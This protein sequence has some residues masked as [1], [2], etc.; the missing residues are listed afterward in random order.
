MK[1]CQTRKLW[2]IAL[3][4]VC[5][6][7]CGGQAQSSVPTEPASP[8][9]TGTP[10]YPQASLPVP[11]FT[12]QELEAM[13]IPGDLDEKSLRSI[14]YM[15]GNKKI[16]MILSM[17][18]QWVQIKPEGAS[19]NQCYFALRADE[20]NQTMF[21]ISSHEEALKDRE[22][23]ETLLSYVEEKWE[24]YRSRQ[25]TEGGNTIENVAAIQKI[26]VGR[27]IGG[28]IRFESIHSNG[29]R[30]INHFII[31]ATDQKVYWCTVTANPSYWVYTEDCMQ[32][33]L[34]GFVTFD[35]AMAMQE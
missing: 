2:L 21:S 8:S 22:N 4:M 6:A 18:I 33:M 19:E 12:S 24:E 28:D 3:A 13:G 1:R 17:P 32:T 16:D 10:A 14:E 26:Q 34:E 31:W 30:T 25:Q 23:E 20:E 35:D 29:V 7:G 11:S 15:Y 27:Y 9:P 5:L